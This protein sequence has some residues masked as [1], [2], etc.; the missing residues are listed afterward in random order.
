RPGFEEGAV[1][2]VEQAAI[3]DG[4]G[5]PRVVRIEDEAEEGGVRALLRLRRGVPREPGLALCDGLAEGAARPVEELAERL[6]HRG[7][8]RDERAD[9]RPRPQPG[10]RRLCRAVGEGEA[11]GAVRRGGGTGGGVFVLL[12]R[13]AGLRG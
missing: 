10:K 2:E 7:L 6:R 13:V 11:G 9:E 8:R 1:A 5:A 3:A 4:D 12:R